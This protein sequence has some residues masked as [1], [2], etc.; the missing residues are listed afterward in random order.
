MNDSSTPSVSPPP[1][2][3]RTPDP[4][5]FHVVSRP[6]IV[7]PPAQK[8]D[9]PPPAPVTPP[10]AVTQPKVGAPDQYSMY[11]DFHWRRTIVWA[12]VALLSAA[13]VVWV[14]WYTSGPMPWPSRFI[15]WVL[16]VVV[17]RWAVRHVRKWMERQGWHTGDAPPSEHALRGA[18]VVGGVVLATSLL[19]STAGRQMVL[20]AAEAVPVVKIVVPD[21]RPPRPTTPAVIPSLPPASTSTVGTPPTVP[22]LPPATLQVPTTAPR[23]TNPTAVV[24]ALP[25]TIARTPPSATIPA[26]TAPPVTTQAL[27]ARTDHVATPVGSAVTIAVLAN[28]DP[29]LVP[30]TV[31]VV[32]RPLG[33]VIVNVDGSLTYTPPAEL[34]GTQSFAYEACTSD[35]QCVQA[36]V[37]VELIG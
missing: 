6:E 29:R 12:A 37:R 15:A 9:D 11:P 18:A 35:D 16:V 4:K 26:T 17:L 36:V 19:G 30:N 22:V 24:P 5:A 31:R 28:D 23:P 8:R 25:S 21:T 3:E 13:G 20:D 1:V 33:D 7:G 14:S 10:P 27:V 32:Q 34:T 2:P